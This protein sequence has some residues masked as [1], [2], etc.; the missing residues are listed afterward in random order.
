MPLALDPHTIVVG[1]DIV[2][3][4]LGF[5]P[6]GRRTAAALQF[7]LQC[8]RPSA[9]VG[10]D[11]VAKLAPRAVTPTSA[12][13]W[14]RYITAG[15]RSRAPGGKNKRARET[16]ARISMTWRTPTSVTVFV[17]RRHPQPG[18]L[19]PRSIRVRTIRPWHVRSLNPAR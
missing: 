4:R 8:A 12:A 13:S 9:D 18:H 14:I 16:A 5:P 1:R 15:K 6:V 10:R 17:L 11:G 3:D 7:V 2:L 19:V